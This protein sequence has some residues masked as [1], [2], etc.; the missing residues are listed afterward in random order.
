[1][2]AQGFTS[3]GSTTAD[4]LLGGEFPRV[5]ELATI[6][7]GNYTKGTILAK[8]TSSGKYTVCIPTASG[9]T[10]DGSETPCAILAESV[11]ASSADKS[12]VIYLTGEFNASALT[13][14]TGNTVAGLKDG[15]RA[16]S[17]FLKTNQGV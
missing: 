14:G 5:S 17:I 3:Q 9:G 11:D 2:P 7:G 13:A 15:L 4:I 12:A 10:A 8:I 1:M 6:T 16:R